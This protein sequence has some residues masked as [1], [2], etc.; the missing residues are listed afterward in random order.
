MSRFNRALALCL[1][2]FCPLPALTDEVRVAVASNFSGVMEPLG[3]AF[4]QQTGHRLRVSLGSTGKHYAQIRQGAP[5]DVFLAADEERPRRLEAEGRGVAGTRFTYATGQ[6]V[7]WSPEEPIDDPAR[8]LRQAPRV[9]M[10]NPRL[11]PYGR[12]AQEVM[13]SL[14]VWEAVGSRAVRGENIAQTYQFVATSNVPLGFV[15]YSQWLTHPRG[16]HWR[17]PQ[18]L[19]PPVAQQAILLRDTP[20]AQSFLTFLQSEPAREL[21][22]AGGYR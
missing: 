20:A 18:A 5:F 14:G 21:I 13:V 16:H 8:T 9:A 1:L 12:A 4:E 10:A 3:A 7:L 22:R 19:Y 17:V 6:L 2:S 11:A 15:A